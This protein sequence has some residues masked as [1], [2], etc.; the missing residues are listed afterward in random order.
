MVGVIDSGIDFRHPDFI[1]RNEKGEP[2]SRVLHFW[3]T[4]SEAYATGIGKPGPVKYPNGA[5]IG[6]IFSQADLT[7]PRTIASRVGRFGGGTRVRAQTSTR[8]PAFNAS[9]LPGSRG[10]GSSRSSRKSGALARAPSGRASSLSFQ[11]VASTR[12]GDSRSRPTHEPSIGVSSGPTSAAAARE[13][14]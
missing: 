3:D 2:T 14:S 5:A 1:T 12:L 7:R 10:A 9:S 6:T 4:F 8:T 13:S 11:L